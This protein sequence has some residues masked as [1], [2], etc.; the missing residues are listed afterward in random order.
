M[1]RG[2]T[3]RFGCAPHT[4]TRT[5]KVGDEHQTNANFH[6]WQTGLSLGRMVVY[7]HGTAAVRP[8]YISI[9]LA[10]MDTLADSPH[11]LTEIYLYERWCSH[12]SRLPIASILC[13]T[14]KISKAHVSSGWATGLHAQEL[15]PQRPSN[16]GPLLRALEVAARVPLPSVRRLDHNGQHFPKAA[17]M[18]VS[19]AVAA[20]HRVGPTGVSTRLGG[21]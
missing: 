18:W 5:H 21:C 20:G 2:K 7:S 10:L 15:V 1:I 19:T 8:P 11:L 6:T 4:H 17:T 12:T 16:V 13:F 9:G 14:P 3:D